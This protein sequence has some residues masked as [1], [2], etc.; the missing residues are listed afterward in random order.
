LVIKIIGDTGVGRM[1][2]RRV[3]SSVGSNAGSNVAGNVDSNVEYK[4][5]NTSQ[6]K[7][8]EK[9]LKDAYNVKLKEWKDLKKTE[10]TAPMPVKP[11]IKK[12]G[13]PYLTQKV[14]Q[15]YVDKLKDEEAEKEDPNAKTTRN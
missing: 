1:G 14:A 6:Y 5:I 11:I 2:G 12:I 9:R 4:V 10:P 3:S 8:E 7:D 13:T 15:E